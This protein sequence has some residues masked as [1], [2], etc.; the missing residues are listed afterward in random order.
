MPL[1]LRDG[2]RFGTLCALDP[3]PERFEDGDLA[4]FRLMADLLAYQLDAEE[5]AEQ[6]ERFVSILAHD[7]RSP[8]SAIELSAR[9]LEGSP[10]LPPALA[11]PVARI[12]RSGERV[13]RMMD[14]LFEVARGRRG[15]VPPIEPRPADAGEILERVVDEL[16]ASHPGHRIELTA[17]RGEE[18][19]WDPDRIAQVFS[20][21]VSNA[22]QHGPPDEPVE[23]SLD[24]YPEEPD[25][26]SV[27]VHNGGDPIPPELATRIFEPYVSA[28]R[29]SASSGKST[30]LGLGLYIAAQA[31]AAHGG[32]LEVASA[33]ETGTTF[34]VLLPRHAPR[35]ES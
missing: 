27:E 5:R 16:A 25:V 18:V 3:D 22:L 6:R 14:D 30:S 32:S 9:V 23:V 1:V 8:L 13:T 33:P 19:L 26:L 11:T 31:T 34:T 10:D 20:N 2:R 28:P 24:V 15:S 4:V 7:V 12:R 29:S 21:L 35:E 17:S